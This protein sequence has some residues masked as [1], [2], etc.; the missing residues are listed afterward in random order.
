MTRMFGEIAALVFALLV[1]AAALAPALAAIS[2]GAAEARPDPQTAALLVLGMVYAMVAPI[3]YFLAETW[4]RRIW[5]VLGAAVAACGIART[6]Y[7]FE[8]RAPGAA[9]FT[10]VLLVA[11]FVIALAWSRA[12]DR[13]RFAAVEAIEAQ[14]AAAVRRV[15]R[16]SGATGRAAPLAERLAAAAVWTAAREAHDAA[17]ARRRI[18]RALAALEADLATNPAIEAAPHAARLLA[19]M[20]RRIAPRRFWP[21]RRRPRP[22]PA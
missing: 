8:V 3:G 19:E 10:F 15:V 7:L 1:S 13:R 6:G 4:E 5:H 20:R 16:E 17:D 2:S 12:A 18:G 21:E 11:A 22:Q 9:I 14:A